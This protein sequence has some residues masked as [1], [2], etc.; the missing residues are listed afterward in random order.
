MEYSVHA[1]RLV[2]SYTELFPGRPTISE[3]RYP[4]D[5]VKRP[6]NNKTADPLTKLNIATITAAEQQTMNYYMNQNG[7]YTSEL[8]RRIYQEIGMIEEQHVSLYGGLMDV[9]ATWLEN[10]LDHEY[11]ECYLYYSCYKDETHPKVKA[12]WEEMLVQEIAHLHKAA[13][14]LKRFE[15]KDWQ[16]VIP[17]G[18]FPQLLSFGP[19]KGYVREVLKQTATLTGSQETYSDVNDLDPKSTFF[20]YQGIVNR[21]PKQNPTHQVIDKHIKDF[22]SDYRYE[23]SP[24]P[25]VELQNR[26]VDNINLGRVKTKVSQNA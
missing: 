14:L 20:M 15:K 9:N 23:D 25:R 7:F 1:E 3:H 19:Q 10:L 8:G 26:T 11:N 18:E 24:N 13:E 16:Q 21:D 6:I 4:F 12:I 2:G 17:V 22:G 5:D